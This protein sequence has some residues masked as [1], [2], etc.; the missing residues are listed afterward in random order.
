MAYWRRSQ[1]VLYGPVRRSIWDAVE[2]LR[3]WRMSPLGNL[4]LGNGISAASASALKGRT[5]RQ[6]RKANLRGNVRHEALQC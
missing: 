4:R 2:I 6:T 3:T 1:C 5:M